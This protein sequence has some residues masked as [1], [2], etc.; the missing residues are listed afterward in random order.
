MEKAGDFI[1][2]FVIC[3]I[4]LRH[5]LLFHCMHCFVSMYLSKRIGFFFLFF[6]FSTF[7]LYRQSMIYLPVPALLEHCL[8]SLFFFFPLLNIKL[9]L[10][11]M[12]PLEYSDPVH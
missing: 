8:M 2:I 9:Y 12:F 5:F 11:Y 3:L 1:L 6:F 10:E 7:C 4:N